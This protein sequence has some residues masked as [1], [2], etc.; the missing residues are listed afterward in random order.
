MLGCISFGPEKLVLWTIPVRPWGVR[1]RW[2]CV[3]VLYLKQQI[4]STK[5]QINFKS[6]AS[7][8]KQISNPKPVQRAAQVLAL[9]ER[10]FLFGVLDFGKLF[11][12]VFWELLLG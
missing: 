1:D 11:F 9:R 10:F 3:G 4:P 2:L 5:L 7:N 6:K 8:S 12:V